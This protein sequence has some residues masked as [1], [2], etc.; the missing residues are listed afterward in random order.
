VCQPHIQGSGRVA[1]AGFG[2]LAETNFDCTQ[3]RKGKVSKARYDS[4]II[5]VMRAL[6]LVAAMSTLCVS[7]FGSEIREF[8]LK[9]I[10]RL[11]N[12]L[13]RVSQTPEKGATTPTRKRAVQT[14]KAAL[15]CKLF[16]IRYD[17]IVLDDPDGSGFLVYALGQGPRRGEVVIH[18]HFRVSVSADG[19]Q[20]KRV[21]GLSH[22]VVIENEYIDPSPQGYH[23][24]VFV[25]S[26]AVGTRPV[27][28]L[29]YASNLMKLTSIERIYFLLV[30]AAVVIEH[31]V[32]VHL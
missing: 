24:V 26:Q 15:Q 20:A 3:L 31:E 6:H 32:C 10:Q 5:G 30:T 2:V 25:T 19:T 1:R 8:D 14:A 21:D 12:E 11:G 28:T 27:E 13:T 17:Y 22:S 23:R 9:T 4:R 29:V 16:N 18:G 7:A